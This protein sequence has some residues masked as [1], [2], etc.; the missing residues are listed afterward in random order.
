MKDLKIEI[1]K[2]MVLDKDKYAKGIVAFISIDGI[3]GTKDFD[4]KMIKCYEDAV[5]VCTVD[6]ENT[7]Y[8]TDSE[9]ISALKKLHHIIKVI[10]NGWTPD[11]SN[12]D[13]YKYNPYFKVSPSGSG[14]SVS[15][16]V[17]HFTYTNVSSRL[18]TDSS[19]KALYLAN[20]FKDLYEQYLLK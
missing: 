11:W 2:G 5:A 6:K 12:E 3:Y 14:F 9:N 13:Q 19:E 10:N 20:Q 1:P 18:L 16:Y 17:Y 7:L 15:S 4:Y 8:D